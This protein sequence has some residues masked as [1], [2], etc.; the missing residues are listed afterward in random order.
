MGHHALR[1]TLLLPMPCEQYGKHCQTIHIAAR[2][3]MSAKTSA[4]VSTGKDKRGHNGRHRE[5][6]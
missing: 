6:S 2:I 1:E 3:S 5:R 4:A